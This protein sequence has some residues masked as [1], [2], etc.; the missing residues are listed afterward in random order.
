MVF[1]TVETLP[2][3]GG[4]RK[5]KK[6]KEKKGLWSINTALGSHPYHQGCKNL[7]GLISSSYLS[8]DQYLHVVSKQY[9]ALH[10]QLK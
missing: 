9:P 2:E 5:E 8:S 7:T 4:E 1:S 6:K 3:K 10:G